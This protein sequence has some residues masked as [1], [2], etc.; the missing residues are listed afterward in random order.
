MN[1][2][3]LSVATICNV[4]LWSLTICLLASCEKDNEAAATTDVPRGAALQ[5]ES[6]LQDFTIEGEPNTRATIDAGKT[7][8][9]VG[10]FIGIF[11]MKDGVLITDCN[12]IKLSYQ[13]NGVWKGQDVYDYGDGV[14]Y[15]AYYPY[16]QE[17]NS[18]TNINE[19]KDAFVIS[20]VQNTPEL[21]TANDLMTATGVKS[22]NNLTFNFTHA[23][24]LLEYYAPKNPQCSTGSAFMNGWHY[25]LHREATLKAI[26]L[27]EKWG[28]S[29]SSDCINVCPAGSDLYRCIVKPTFT[30]ITAFGYE[31]AGFTS[32]CKYDGWYRGFHAEHTATY[33]A[34]SYYRMNIKNVHSYPYGG[35]FL[36]K[37]GTV[38][39][40]GCT[41][42]DSGNCVGIIVHTYSD[43][44][45]A[46]IPDY[47]G[48]PLENALHGYAAALHDA[49]ESVQYTTVST[50]PFEYSRKDG[51]RYTKYQVEQG[52]TKYPAAYAAANYKGPLPTIPNSGC[53]F[54]SHL[55]CYT[56]VGGGN[57]SMGKVGGD[58]M[59]GDYWS[60]HEGYELY[61]Y[62][63]IT[64]DRDEMFRGDKSQYKKVRAVFSF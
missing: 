26:Q 12:N 20:N 60:N 17:M 15:F 57:Y 14:S 58:Y 29:E 21:L 9:T 63:T 51:Y 36:Y 2:S 6:V 10:D 50:S 44:L 59:I 37:D 34:G 55:I 45:V 64:M 24:C 28:E 38:L 11:A 43:M 52:Q 53:W 32:S 18:K 31:I 5:V 42:V 39:P 27:H 23:F 1:I 22:G 49:A 61:Y 30:S 7:T 47:I 35:A 46:S 4:T 56:V 40:A 62:Y 41:D 13:G 48:T 25:K 19:I 54:L 3:K 8:F 33:A 16:N